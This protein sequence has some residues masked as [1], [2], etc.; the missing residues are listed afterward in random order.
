MEE[1]HVAVTHLVE[2][3]D[4]MTFTKRSALGSLHGRDIRDITI[5]TDSIV[6]DEVTDLLNQA[7]IAYDNV[8]QRG[9]VDTRVLHETLRYFYLFLENAQS[10]VA[11][12]NDAVEVIR[13][14][15]LSNLYTLPVFSPAAIV[16]QYTN[17]IICQK[18]V[19]SHKCIVFGSIIFIYLLQPPRCYIGSRYTDISGHGVHEHACRV[20]HAA[21]R[22]F[23]SAWQR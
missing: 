8:T 14:K 17:L 11:V 5:V 23:P 2:H 10:D 16:F 7:V 4:K 20:F 6:I 3:T 19:V 13:R 12:E 18:S 15:F 1:H 22:Y 9:I 21:C